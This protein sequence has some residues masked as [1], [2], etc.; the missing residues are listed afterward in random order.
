MD[1]VIEIILYAFLACLLIRAIFSWFE[2]Y[3]R[4]QIH[5]FT[6]DVTE[7]I[8]A[9][10][11]RLVPPLGGFDIAFIIVFFGVSLLL[12]LVQRAL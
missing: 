7:P 10:V 3:P 5:R 12:Q 4:N 11:R 1:V 2:P 8:V 6:F 9:P